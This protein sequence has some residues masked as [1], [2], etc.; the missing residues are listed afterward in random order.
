MPRLDDLILF[1][2]IFVSVAA[3]VVFPDAG[4]VF[5]PYLLVF[6]MLL[7]FLSFLRID[8][9]SLVNISPSVLR[10]LAMMAAV[11]LI[12]LPVALYGL[13]L[14]IIPD[15]AIPVLLLSGISTGVVAPFIATLL[16]ADVAP[17][18]RMVIVTS[19]L[20]PFSL[21]CLVKLLEG[22]EIAIPLQTMIQLLAVVILVPM[23]AVLFFRRL[24]PGV[25][26][27]IAS[28]RFPFSLILF[29][30]INLGVF[31]KYS[32][33]L[34]QHPKQ[35][36]VSTAVAYALSVIYYMVGFLITPRRKIPE[37]LAAG[38]S[39]ALMNNV[40]VIV[41][42]SE[43]FGPLSPTLAAMYMFPFFTMIV[44]IKILAGRRAA[45]SPGETSNS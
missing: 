43:F 25:I 23:V 3:A 2:V 12:V 42:S 20:V 31:S 15:Y 27:G 26:E 35:L 1:A 41:F 37:R 36:L 17:V 28:R 16:G 21:P 24:L 34:F 5:Q 38:I 40:L 7:M 19:L 13:A 32:N 11:K 45:T 14:V 39:L 4:K 6:M 18:L 30:L 22:S 10:V 9:H 44:P 8:F 33:F 29:A